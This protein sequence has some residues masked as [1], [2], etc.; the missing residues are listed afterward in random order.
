MTPRDLKQYGREPSMPRG[1]VN[2]CLGLCAVIALL[3]ALSLVA[4]VEDRLVVMSRAEFE[5]Q[6]AAE[7]IKAAQEILEATECRGNWRDLFVEPK[8][9]KKWSKT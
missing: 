9:I 1:I 7:R 2:L 3:T 6:V 5:R 4:D 8:R